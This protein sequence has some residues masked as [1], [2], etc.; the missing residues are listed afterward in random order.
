MNS[1]I[2]NEKYD[3]KIVKVMLENKLESFEPV[4]RKRVKKQLKQLLNSLDKNGFVRRT[5]STT[6]CGIGRQ[7]V[8]ETKE[9]SYQTMKKDLRHTLAKDYYE[10]VD[11]ENAHPVIL[12]YMLKKMNVNHPELYDYI[13]NREIKLKSIIEKCKCNRK[14]AKELLLTILYLGSIENYM[15]DNEITEMPPK[16]VYEYD[17]EMKINADILYKLNIDLTKKAG[18]TKRD[19]NPKSSLLSVI[20]GV[21]ENKI[22]MEAKTFLEMKGFTIDALMFDGFFVRK[23]CNLKNELLQELSDHVLQNLGY[24]IV[25]SKKP[26]NDTIDYLLIDE[27]EDD[28]EVDEDKLSCIDWEYLNEISH[29]ENEDITYQRKKKYLEHFICKIDCPTTCYAYNIEKAENDD[30]PDI[31]FKQK[32]DMK[33]FLE[34]VTSGY[35]NDKG[36]PKPFFEVWNKDNKQ[37]RFH[38]FDFIP[39]G[40]DEENNFENK[41]ILN[42]FSGFKRYETPSKKKQEMKY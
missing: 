9:L 41:N 4:D 15:F 31:Y 28:W 27:F 16:W 10:D 11:M 14:I 38:R 17:E 21:E 30:E 25:F 22:L 18:I 26:M 29:D 1:T 6:K 12:S 35:Y 23:P 40:I 2:L 20:I 19:K 7:Y 3:K 42:L 24:N 32:N 34:S 37:R 36:H 5:Y 33:D 8:Q 13:T 39:Y